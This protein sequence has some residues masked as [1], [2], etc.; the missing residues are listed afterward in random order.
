M[1]TATFW[2]ALAERAIK[3]ACQVLA[4]ALVA[5]GTGLI[6]T[7]WTGLLSMAGMAALVSALTSIGTGAITDGN[8]AVGSR[9]V[10]AEPGQTGTSGDSEPVEV[11]TYEPRRAEDDPFA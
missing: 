7:Q 6:D 4:A 3:T 2:Q 1:W 10:L 8:P 5:D 9:E 11:E